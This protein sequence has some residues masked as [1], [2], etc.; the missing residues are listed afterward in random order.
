[1]FSIANCGKWQKANKDNEYSTDKSYK[2]VSMTKIGQIFDQS[3]I[4]SIYQFLQPTQSVIRECLNKNC[5]SYTL[6]NAWR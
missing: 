1:M 2:T 5:L 6:Y 4:N 3:E